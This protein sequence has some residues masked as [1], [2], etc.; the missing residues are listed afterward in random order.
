MQISQPWVL[1]VYL[2]SRELGNHCYNILT[3]GIVHQGVA[4]SMLWWIPLFM[5]LRLINTLR[6]LP[7]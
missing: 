2:T 5:I 3:L 7:Q 6:Q 4:I 1:S